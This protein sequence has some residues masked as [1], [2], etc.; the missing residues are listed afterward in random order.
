MKG[1]FFGPQSRKGAKQNKV[2]S[3]NLRMLTVASACDTTEANSWLHN[4]ATN[5]F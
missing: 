3:V 5:F 4:N 1:F 2:S